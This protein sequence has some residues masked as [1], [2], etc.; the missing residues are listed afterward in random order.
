MLLSIIRISNLMQ[1]LIHI[2]T[3][4]TTKIKVKNGI[5]LFNIA[6]S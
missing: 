6:Q 4:T 5:H 2:T 1:L 3:T